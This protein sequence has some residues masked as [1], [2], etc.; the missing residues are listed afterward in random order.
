M[1]ILLFAVTT[2]AWLL[3]L[4]FKLTRSIYRS[5]MATWQKVTLIG[6]LWFCLIALGGGL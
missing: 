2:L 1:I 4:P 5:R 6:G 3:W